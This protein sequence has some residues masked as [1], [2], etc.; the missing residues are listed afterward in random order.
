MTG[1]AQRGCGRGAARAAEGR[2]GQSQCEDAHRP[3]GY[4]CWRCESLSATVGLVERPSA[5]RRWE[6]VCI[7]AVAVVFTAIR[8]PLFTNDGLLLGWNSDAAIFGLM[9]R[10]IR[11]GSD[12]PLYFWG[13]FYLGTLTSIF[14]AL[15]AWLMRAPEI[16]PATLRVTAALEGF[17][18]ILFFWLGLRRT[19]G[20]GA[21]MTAAFW[22]AAGPAF[23]FHFTIAPIGAEQL[24]FAASVLFWYATRVRLATASEWLVGGIL[25]G[26]FLWLHQGIAFLIAGVAVAAF[27]ER[28]VTARAVVFGAIGMAIGY[29]P[30][31][32]AMLRDEPLLYARVITRWSLY[33]VW[34][35][36]L[37]TIRS[38]VWLLLADATPVGIL[39]GTC[40]LAF[41][42]AGMRGHERTRGHLIVL[43]TIA[44]SVAFW[45]F[46]T[47]PY[48][49]AVRYVVPMVPFLYGAAALGLLRVHR[50][51]RAGKI[52]ALT[53]ALA[54]TVGLFVPRIVQARDVAAGRSEQYS[55][56]PGSFDPRPVLD[57]LRRGRYRVCYGEVWVAH[58]LEWLSDPP[59]RFVPVRSVHRT[60]RRSLR[61]IREPGPKCL[62]GNDG[63]IRR[64]S[65]AEE[66]MWAATVIERARKAGLKKLE[67]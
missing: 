1:V 52:V 61:A 23:L 4:R 26:L 41:A 51:G 5:I 50:D 30:A 63:S 8:V 66:R 33:A 21:A 62:V 32:L 56:W 53:G 54:I 27:A 49:G 17:A 28:I 14:T 43:A 57:E 10:A 22:L 38:D 7:L 59:V 55:N 3:A 25:C 48:P 44:V 35:T 31:V 65:D 19:Y 37:E 36:V 45:L 13:Q 12:T 34:L 60:L 40:I 29:I 16:G 15:G 20:T 11:E 42:I 46:S 6:W 18:S 24:F 9:A 2:D 58:K 67:N 47:F 39:T 64:L